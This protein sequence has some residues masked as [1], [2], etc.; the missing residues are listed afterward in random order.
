MYVYARGQENEKCAVL[1][2]SYN[3]VPNMIA[4]GTCT[5]FRRQTRNHHRMDTVPSGHLKSFNIIYIVFVLMV[6]HMCA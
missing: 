6:H 1:M 5:F 3:R 4:H 2:G